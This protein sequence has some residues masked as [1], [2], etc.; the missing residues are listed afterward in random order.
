M[1][2]R[3]RSRKQAV[4][5]VRLWLSASIGWEASRG[6]AEKTLK[7]ALDSGEVGY[8]LASMLPGMVRDEMINEEDLACWMARHFPRPDLARSSPPAKNQE[9]KPASSAKI[10]QIV[11]AVYN[12]AK[13]A[14]RK[15][16]N[17]DKELPKL[18]QQKLSEVGL[19]SS[20][21]RIAKIGEEPEF[22][23]RRRK[24][25]K[26]VASERKK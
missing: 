20:K 11:K 7:N 21:R 5:G 14:G 23:Q 15:P 24:P 1:A 8:R 12:E 3:W 22:A 10:R 19:T 2:E 18:V 26:T 6:Y 25:G 17:K 4:E 16:P 13:N 9:S